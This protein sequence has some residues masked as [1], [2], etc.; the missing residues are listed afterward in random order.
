VFGFSVRTVHGGGASA[1]RQKREQRPGMF[2]QNDKEAFDINY[3]KLPH[4]VQ[5]NTGA[6][7]I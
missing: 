4:A 1:H 7:T 5:L 2:Y 6:Q 3:A